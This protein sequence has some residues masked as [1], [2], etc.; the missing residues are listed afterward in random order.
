V[1]SLVPWHKPQ[2]DEA[3]RQIAERMLQMP[4]KPHEEMKLGKKRK[5]QGSKRSQRKKK[6]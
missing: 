3:S 6:P 5:T 1:D 2:L 4:P